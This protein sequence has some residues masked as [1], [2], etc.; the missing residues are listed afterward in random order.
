[1]NLPAGKDAM[2]VAE[3]YIRW[4]PEAFGLIVRTEKKESG[5]CRMY[6]KG[7]NLLLLELKYLPNK[8]NAELA[9]YSISGGLLLRKGYEHKGTFE[10]RILLEKKVVLTAIHD[11]SPSLPWFVYT[12]S[13]AQVHL[14]VMRRFCAHINHIEK[15]ERVHSLFDT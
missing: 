4:L 3:E 5:I 8:S 12:L 13:Q 9:K 10:F 15:N 11:F 7:S 6:L 1:M 2:W 14:F